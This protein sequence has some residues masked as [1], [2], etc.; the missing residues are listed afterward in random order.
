M[1]RSLIDPVN[2]LLKTLPSSERDLIISASNQWV[3][4]FDNLSGLSQ[5]SSDSLCRLA[6]GGGFSTRQLYTD[7]DEVQF[8]LI[9]PIILNG[10][11]DFAHQPDLID[12]MVF[13]HLPPI[14]GTKRIE[15]REFWAKFDQARPFIFGAIL[16][17]L[18]AALKNLDGVRLNEK[19][20]MAD[21]ARFATAAEPALGCPP[22]TFLMAYQKNQSSAV[23]KCLEDDPV[24]SALVR[25]MEEKEMWEG[26]SQDLLV[27]LSIYVPDRIHKS[28]SWPE[29]PRGLSNRVRRLVPSLRTIGIEVVPPDETVWNPEEKKSQR[30]FRIARSSKKTVICVCSVM[31][32]EKPDANHDPKGISSTDRAVATTQLSTETSPDASKV[33]DSGSRRRIAL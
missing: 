19:P 17:A 27:D 5:A 22:G 6:T 18:S 31:E 21:F 1:I 23:E 24:A 16:D 10:I 30:L 4:A 15:E 33:T 7:S 20:R 8:N 2:T 11:V 14:A 32:K 25:L 29:S 3:L 28:K 12:R 13:L 26:T 9:R